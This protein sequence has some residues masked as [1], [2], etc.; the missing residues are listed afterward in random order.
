MKEYNL[1]LVTRIIFCDDLFSVMDGLYNNLVEA[2]TSGIPSL[3]DTM[4]ALN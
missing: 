2:F 4:L 3:S 1:K